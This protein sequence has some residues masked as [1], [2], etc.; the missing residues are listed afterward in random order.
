MVEFYEINEVYTTEEF[1]LTV[2]NK[3]EGV[4]Y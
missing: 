4:F 2:L 3:F 1:V